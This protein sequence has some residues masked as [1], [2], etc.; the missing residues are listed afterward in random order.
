MTL[1]CGC[2]GE[3]F[4]YESKLEEQILLELWHNE[5][6]EREAEEEDNEPPSGSTDLGNRGGTTFCY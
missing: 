1:E 3:C 4:C 2:I 6:T 5:N